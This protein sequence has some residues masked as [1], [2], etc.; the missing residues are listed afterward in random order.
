MKLKL[1]S[2]KKN[3]RFKIFNSEEGISLFEVLISISLLIIVFIPFSNL[4]V[5]LINIDNNLEIQQEIIYIAQK[6]MEKIKDK[7]FEEL[8]Q[9]EGT[10]EIK[11][12]NRKFKQIITC[13]PVSAQSNRIK[14]T[15]ID[16]KYEN[17]V[18]LEIRTWISENS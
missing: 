12:N 3:N 4:L 2:I 6:K 13:E 5:K 7:N 15:V 16:K 8:Q 1:L 9:I 17:E 18:V 11:F 10:D 14:V